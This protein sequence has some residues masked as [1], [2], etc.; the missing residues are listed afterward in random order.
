MKRTNNKSFLIPFAAAT[1]FLSACGSAASDSSELPM[2]DGAEPAAEQP[3][4]EP[5]DELIYNTDSIDL[6]D[7]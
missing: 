6:A 5:G 4:S 2:N 1:L 7:S 3:L